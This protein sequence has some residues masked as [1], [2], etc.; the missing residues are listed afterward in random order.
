MFNRVVHHLNEK[1]DLMRVTPFTEV[2]RHGCPNL[3][4][5]DGKFYCVDGTAYPEQYL[6]E[7]ILKKYAPHLIKKKTEVV[8]EDLEPAKKR[9]RPKKQEDEV[10][11][12]LS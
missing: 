6:T 2:I 7:D 8:A 4:I 9:G 3:L 5:R 10:D 11:E 12:L 1:G